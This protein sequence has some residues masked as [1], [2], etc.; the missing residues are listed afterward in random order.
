MFMISLY[1]TSFLLY[2]FSKKK[3][4]KKKK[5]KGE[6]EIKSSYFFIFQESIPPEA[7]AKTR[8]QAP[9]VMPP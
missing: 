9:H 1:D 6:V 4:K 3:K 5:K 7:N 8:A 2:S